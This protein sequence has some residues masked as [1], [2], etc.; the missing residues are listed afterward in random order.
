MWYEEHLGITSDTY[1]SSFEWRS[2]RDASRKGFTLWAPFPADTTY[3]HPSV[4]EFMLSFRVSDIIR[5]VADLEKEGVVALDSIASYA[6]G[7]FVHIMDVEGNK[8]ELW[9]PVD[10][11]YEKNIGNARMF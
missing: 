8:I 3:F 4:K 7:K 6:Y 11:V 2:T 9:E 10:E 1:G 5:V